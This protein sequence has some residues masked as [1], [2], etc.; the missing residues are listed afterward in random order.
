MRSGSVSGPCPYY[1]HFVVFNSVIEV[2]VTCAMSDSHHHDW[3]GSLDLLQIFPP[4]IKPVLLP[5]HLTSRLPGSPRI[6]RSRVGVSSL[7]WIIALNG[8]PAGCMIA[9]SQE[10]HAI[11]RSPHSA[12]LQ[13]SLLPMLMRV[14]I[15][16]HA[17]VLL[18]EN[19]VFP[20]LRPA[21]PWLA[22]ES[23]SRGAAGSSRVGEGC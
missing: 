23:S 14:R 2:K 11:P 18:T 9:A 10:A 3:Q 8:S 21:F 7:Q 4:R 16:I 12:G 15:T 19:S 6:L 1:L 13:H 20:C 22:I 17:E 5:A